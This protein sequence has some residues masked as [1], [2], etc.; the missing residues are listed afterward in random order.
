M[1]RENGNSEFKV[2]PNVMNMNLYVCTASKISDHT[3]VETALLAV[4][5]L[6]FLMYTFPMREST[7]I[8]LPVVQM[9]PRSLSHRQCSIYAMPRRSV[10]PTRLWREC[11]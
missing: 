9:D 6:S 10:I 3:R 2:H 11:R 8:Q 1:R 4:D 5:Y 7:H